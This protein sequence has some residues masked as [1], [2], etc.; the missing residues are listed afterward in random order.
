[1]VTIIAHLSLMVAMLLCIWDS[2]HR[3]IS[4]IC[5]KKVATVGEALAI[6]EERTDLHPTLP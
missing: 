2:Q 4:T 3:V 6:L 5:N 1:M